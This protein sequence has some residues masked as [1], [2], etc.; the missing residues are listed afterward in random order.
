[1]RKTPSRVLIVGSGNIAQRHMR[2][3]RSLFPGAAVVCVSSS[4]R[5]LEVSEVPA[6]EVS[7]SIEEA[8]DSLPDFAIVASP[9]NLH[10]DHAARILERD[11]P[12]LV[13]KP[14]CLSLREKPLCLLER[15]FERVGVGYNLR[16]L[17][18]ARV[19]KQILDKE[20]LGKIT[21]AFAEVGQYLPDWRPGTDYKSGVSAQKDLGGGAL[22]ELSHELDYLQ[23][24][25]GNFTHVMA[26]TRNSGQLGI[27]V[28]DNVD[29]MLISAEHTVVHL[30]LD[31]LQRV[32]ARTFKVVGEKATLV[33]DLLRNEVMILM[34]GGER[35][36]AFSDPSYDRNDMYLDQVNAFVDFAL[37]AGRFDSTLKTAER[38]MRLIDAIRLSD[39]SRKWVSMEERQ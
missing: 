33:W 16:F 28:E 38:V 30:H 20:E 12:V 6:T 14:L 3:L 39:S 37:G 27:D 34:P 35:Q 21:T 1:M 15:G 10:L 2:N 23:W 4:G 17:P 25:F 8:L 9:A 11:I 18:S 32:P 5:R 31:F 24:F 36:R 22:L 7:S 26:T 29:A 13:E 19:V